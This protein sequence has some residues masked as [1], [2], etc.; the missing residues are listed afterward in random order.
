MSSV[1]RTK[2]VLLIIALILGVALL[3]TQSQAQE[4]AVGQAIANVLAAI[5]V[6]AVQDLDFGDILQGVTAAVP[7]TDAANSGIFQIA[8]EATGNRE[9]SMTMSLPEFLWN[10]APGNQDRLVVYFKDTD[11]TIDTT[12]GTP[13]APGGGALTNQNPHNLPD[14]G[15]GGA[16]GVIRLYLGGAVYPTVNQRS[17]FYSADITLTA[18][19]TGD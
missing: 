18:S 14:T 13:D 16:D 12:N 6:T 1:K 5:Q 17:G 4:T 2:S 10:N 3:P 8:G 9:V 7:P 11:I 15:I 19:Y